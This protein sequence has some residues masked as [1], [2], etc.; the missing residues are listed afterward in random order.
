[1]KI[2]LEGRSIVITGGTGALGGAVVETALEAG[3]RCHIPAIE[4]TPPRHL[5]ER[6]R[7]HVH[8]GV[9][10]T[11]EASVVSFYE[12]LP[13]LW[14]SVHL[15][16]GFAM[17]PVTE[18]GLD[19]FTDQFSMNAVTCFLCC[20]EAVR[21]MRKHAGKGGRIVNVAASPVLAP[22]GGMIA[23]ATA[24]TAV[25]AITQNL[26]EE[27]KSEKILVNAIVPSIIDTPANREAMPDADHAAWPK[28]EELARAILF[29]IAADNTLTTGALV[30]VRGRL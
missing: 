4:E 6:E 22:T 3:A 28:P 1:M 24:K 25:A 9:D 19:L 11:V 7:L 29:L 5:S 14:A 17:T 13:R 10:L 18:T 30:P 20:R 16:G 15:A 8:T 2:D 21:A 12:T 23:Y 27:I 26:A